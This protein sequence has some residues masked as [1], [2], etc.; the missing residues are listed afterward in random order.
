MKF[1]LAGLLCLHVTLAAA[2]MILVPISVQG[3]HGAN[4]SVWTSHLSVTNRSNH[5][6]AVAGISED[7]GVPLCSAPFLPSESSFESCT[8]GSFVEIIEGDA[9]D[10]AFLLRVQDTS[11]QAQTWGTVIPTVREADGFAGS[12]K[13]ELLDIPMRPELRSLL[14]IYDLHPGQQRAVTIRFYEVRQTECQPPTVSDH[15]LLQLS[16]SFVQDETNPYAEPPMIVLPLWTVNELAGVDRLRI[17]IESNSSD[18]VFWA[19]ASVTN[20]ETQ[21]FTAVTP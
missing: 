13:L 7:C 20:N 12:A 11:R 6:V 14:R 18:L 5:A 9:S 17:E 4:G 21:H 8:F 3:A 1:F 2:E 16:T 15:L 19:F 10:V